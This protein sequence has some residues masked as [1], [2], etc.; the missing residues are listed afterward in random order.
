MIY[1]GR[2]QQH[3]KPSCAVRTR[4]EAKALSYIKQPAAMLGTLRA[5]PNDRVVMRPSE[6][7]EAKAAGQKCS[8]AWFTPR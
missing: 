5:Y 7:F 6:K 2:L 1:N 4:K 8:E 3:D